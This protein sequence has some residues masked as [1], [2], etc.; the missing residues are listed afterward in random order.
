MTFNYSDLKNIHPK[1]C[2]IDPGLIHDM[3]WGLEM[4]Y[5]EAERLD[6]VETWKN[7]HCCKCDF[8]SKENI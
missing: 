6:E 5:Q 1:G 8:H 7:E 4:A 3:C 2:N